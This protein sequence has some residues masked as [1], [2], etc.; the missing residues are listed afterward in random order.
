MEFQKPALVILAAGESRRLGECKALVA[1]TPRHPL[2]LLLAAGACCD[3]VPPLVVT[4]ADHAKIVAALPAGVDVVL[5]ADWAVSRSAG[6]RAAADIRA[7]RDLLLAPVDVPLVPR[8]VFDRLLEA[9][10][11]SGSPA[12]GWLAPRC[13]TRDDSEKSSYGHP[14]LVG[15]NLVRDLEA[16]ALEAPLRELRRRAAPVF[17][18]DVRSRAILDDLDTPA[19]LSRLRARGSV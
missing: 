9:W 14:I 1:L 11:A 13:R 16:M 3:D 12:R 7:D 19:D 2:E 15:R 8:E 17:S 4:G 5:N 18:V 6:V 10:R